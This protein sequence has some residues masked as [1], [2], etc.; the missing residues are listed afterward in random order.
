MRR[1]C[2]RSISAHLH[3]PTRRG[4]PESPT[5][6]VVDG[7]CSQAASPSPCPA[8]AKRV[9]APSRHRARPKSPGAAPARTGSRG[10]NR[11]GEPP[12]ALPT[13]RRK[14]SPKA[15]TPGWGCD[16]LSG[17]NKLLPYSPSV[18]LPTADPLSLCYFFRR[19]STSL[20]RPRSSCM[21]RT[22]GASSDRLGRPPT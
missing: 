4:F 12:A 15:A 21:P 10:R 9:P 17:Q 8:P 6:K 20:R 14:A 19:I 18:R 16:M 11:F 22:G 5:P 2:V 7:R 1:V 3:L 13:R